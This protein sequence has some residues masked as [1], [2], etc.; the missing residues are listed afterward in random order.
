MAA[1]TMAHRPVS[2]ATT[3]MLLM[4][5]R[6]TATMARTT[7]Q[8]ACSL[9]PDPGSVAATVVTASVAVTAGTA[10]GMVLVSAAV[11]VADTAVVKLSAQAEALVAADSM[12]AAAVEASTAAVVVDVGKLNLD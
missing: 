2:M 1:T 12:A 11:M 8:A 4:P 5:A 6:P 9:A 10:V 3:A 7:S